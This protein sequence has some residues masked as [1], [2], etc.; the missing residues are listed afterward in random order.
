MHEEVNRR[1]GLPRGPPP[2]RAEPDQVVPA[3]AR[4]GRGMLLGQQE[5]GRFLGRR[6]GVEEAHGRAVVVAVLV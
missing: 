4:E 1:L 6:E 3:P 2:P 5:R